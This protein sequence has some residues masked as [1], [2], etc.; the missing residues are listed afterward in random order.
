[1]PGVLV[2]FAFCF[3]GAAGDFAIPALLGGAQSPFV[4]NQV[5]FQIG[6]TA[7]WPLAAAMAITLI[8]LVVLIVAV[9]S[10]V[11]RRAIR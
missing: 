8:V 1:M 5:Q 11:G 9:V 6:Q 7:N 10:W 2:A 3:I 4:G